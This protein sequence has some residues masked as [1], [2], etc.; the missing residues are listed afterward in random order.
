LPTGQQAEVAA[1]VEECPRCA[2]EVEGYRALFVALSGLPHFEPSLDFGAA[3]MAR[4]RIPP[5]TD[6]LFARFVRAL[7]STR[8]GWI[9]LVLACMVPA[10]PVIALVA[11]LVSQPFFAPGAL[12]EWGTAWLGDTGWSLLTLGLVA[13]MESSA[14]AWG[15]LLVERL[16]AMPVEILAGGALV[17]AVGIPLSA[18]TLYRLL[19][20]PVGGTVYAH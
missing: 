5:A 19:R 7:P 2:S 4:V 18:W 3:V 8:R 12:I 13:V 11:W 10:L 6:P 16:L 15:S 9:L 17:L 14:L 20:T 1:H